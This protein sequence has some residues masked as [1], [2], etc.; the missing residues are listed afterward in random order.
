MTQTLILHVSHADMAQQELL[1]TRDERDNH[2]S[3]W[4]MET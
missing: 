2:L 4:K 3:F 1:T